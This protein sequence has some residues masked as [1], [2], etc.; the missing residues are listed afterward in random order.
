[1]PVLIDEAGLLIAGHG[2]VLAARMLGIEEVPVVVATG[3]SEAKRKA[4]ALADN[5]LALNAGW[6]QEMLAFELNDLQALAFDMSLIG[7]SAD[8]LAQLTADRT[9]GL[10]DPDDSPDLPMAPV[11][12][13]GDVWL[14]GKHQ[15]ACGD[16]TDPIV[17]SRLLAGAKPHLMV[18]DPPYGVEYDPAWRVRQGASA[19]T[20]KMAR[21]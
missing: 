7:F 16:C 14:L 10:T 3:W 19:R 2:R 4:Y 17:V 8:E 5:Q 15:L 6:N 20:K 12:A 21:F 13:P 9:V 18:T 11:S 1:V